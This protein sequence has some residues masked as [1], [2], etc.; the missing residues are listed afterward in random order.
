MTTG[1]ETPAYLVIGETAPE[2]FVPNG[3][4]NE[5]SDVYGFSLLGQFTLI[6]C[7]Q[8]PAALIQQGLSPNPSER[9][10]LADIMNHLQIL[11]QRFQQ[12]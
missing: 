1:N 9:P 5:Q 2:L 11:L 4:P 12:H 6:N 10:S 7:Q 3:R 8:L